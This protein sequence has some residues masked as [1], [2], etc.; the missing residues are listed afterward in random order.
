MFSSGGC[1][2]QRHHR[3]PAMLHECPR[4]L[5]QPLANW[6]E[7]IM[8]SSTPPGCVLLHTP[9]GGRGMHGRWRCGLRRS[10]FI[11]PAG[12]LAPPSCC[13]ASFLPCL[14]HLPQPLQTALVGLWS[15]QVLRQT[16][17][18]ACMHARGAGRA[19]PRAQRATATQ[20]PK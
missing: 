18:R 15:S 6:V 19:P 14:L 13:P 8:N 20:P 12:K 17:P 7:S 11:P 1:C 9:W 16:S 4:C 5:G 3:P 10:C 2:T